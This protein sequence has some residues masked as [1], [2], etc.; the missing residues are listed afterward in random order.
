MLRML[1]R[2]H[3]QRGEIVLNPQADLIQDGV[4]DVV[5]QHIRA[6][7]DLSAPLTVPPGRSAGSEARSAAPARVSSRV[8]WSRLLVEPAGGGVPS[9]VEIEKWRILPVGSPT[10]NRPSGKTAAGGMRHGEAYQEVGA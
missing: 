6:H 3:K 7:V 4:W 10:T 1:R 5:K 9:G 8:V 2:E